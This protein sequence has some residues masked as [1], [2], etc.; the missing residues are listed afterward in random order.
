MQ[1]QMSVPVDI[2]LEQSDPSL[3][4]GGEDIFDL[5][6]TQKGLAGRGEM[7]RFVEGNAQDSSEEELRDDD[8]EDSEIEV[9]AD[10]EQE[11]KTRRLEGA[12]DGLYDAYRQ[13]LSERDAKYKVREA[14]RKDKDREEWRGIRD[15]GDE[16]EDTDGELQEGGWEHVQRAKDRGSDTS[17]SSDEDEDEMPI[18]QKRRKPGTSPVKKPGN[19]STSHSAADIWFSRDVF[20]DVGDLDVRDDKVSEDASSAE[21]DEGEEE[22]VLGNAEEPVSVIYVS[23]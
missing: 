21:E 9:D 14:R 12:L 23:L 18:G 1:L 10:D 19:T 11:V 22:D 5:G 13:R 3:Q 4:L 6:D 8:T 17:S 7:R 2:G 20:R 15:D 16:D